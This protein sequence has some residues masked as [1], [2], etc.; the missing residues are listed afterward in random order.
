MDGVAERV[1]RVPSDSVGTNRGQT[2]SRS[3]AVDSSRN[4]HIET[5]R[6]EVRESLD[7]QKTDAS[8]SS[9]NPHVQFK[10]SEGTRVMEVYDSKNILIYQVPPKGLLTLI[11]NQEHQPDPQIETS[12]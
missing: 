1:K 7:V 9:S 4:T 3:V 2:E 12:A 11:H 6:K 10:I 5:A 8:A